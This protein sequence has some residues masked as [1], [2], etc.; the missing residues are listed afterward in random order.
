MTRRVCGTRGRL[1][2]HAPKSGTRPI[3][4][5]SR[6]DIDVGDVVD[7]NVIS[8]VGYVCDNGRMTCEVEVFGGV[9]EYAGGMKV[10]EAG[11]ENSCGMEVSR[12]GGGGVAWNTRVAWKSH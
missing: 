8:K 7:G 5:S 10:W 6:T 3:M 11:V 4:V 2:E 1:G 9:V 12:G